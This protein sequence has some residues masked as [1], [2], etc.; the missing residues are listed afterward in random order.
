[1]ENLG[2]NLPQWMVLIVIIVYGVVKLALEFANKANQ[3][4]A[5]AEAEADA[6]GPS[7]PDPTGPHVIEKAL[8]AREAKTRQEEVLSL[9]RAQTEL[10]ATM[11]DNLEA[12]AQIQR[13]QAD[14]MERLER[15]M[16]AQTKLLERQGALIEH[17]Q[18]IGEMLLDTGRNTVKNQ[19]KV[20]S[21]VLDYVER[22]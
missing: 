17:N 20:L 5:K 8:N 16:S 3:R 18:R 10:S 7:K 2:S 9:T 14:V 22:E 1:M 4:A 6:K 15:Q 13:R 11:S 21:R 19:A 12:S